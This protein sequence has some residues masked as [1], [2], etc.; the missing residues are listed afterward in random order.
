MV[1]GPLWKLP[2]SETKPKYINHNAATY[3]VKISNKGRR[4]LTVLEA[5]EISQKGQMSQRKALLDPISFSRRVK[6]MHS[7]LNEIN[8]IVMVTV[9]TVI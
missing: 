3:L 2:Y 9:S 5:R 6:L 4:A 7:S 8:R 1:K